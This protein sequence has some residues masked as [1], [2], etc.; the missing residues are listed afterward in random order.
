MRWNTVENKIEM[1][2]IDVETLSDESEFDHVASG[3]EVVTFVS[4]VGV[5]ETLIC[6]SK[7][8]VSFTM[9]VAMSATRFVNHPKDDHRREDDDHPDHRN[10]RS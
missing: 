10:S 2:F 3:A 6:F 7:M 5:G 4:E 1:L 8:N 9:C